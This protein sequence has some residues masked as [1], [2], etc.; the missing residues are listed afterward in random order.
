MNYNP[1]VGPSKSNGGA[2][3]AEVPRDGSFQV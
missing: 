1:S 3:I 2:K